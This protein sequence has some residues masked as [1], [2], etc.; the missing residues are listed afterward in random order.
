TLN[1]WRPVR[2][3]TQQSLIA[4]HTPDQSTN[5]LT[6]SASPISPRDKLNSLDVNIRFP[7]P[8]SHH[9]FLAA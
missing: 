6:L 7:A 3:M 5:S 9:N 2:S 4:E 1:E 8:K